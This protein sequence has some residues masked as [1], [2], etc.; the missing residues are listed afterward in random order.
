MYRY[1]ADDALA[2]AARHFRQDPAVSQVVVCTTDTDLYQEARLIKSLA[3]LYDNLPMPL[4][5]EDLRW[6]HVQH[7]RLAE[8]IRIAEAHDLVPRLERWDQYSP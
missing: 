6:Q 2:T 4:S 1:Q 5:L 7:D 8:I 3:V